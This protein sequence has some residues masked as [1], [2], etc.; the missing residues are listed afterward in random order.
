MIFNTDWILT[1]SS[2]DTITQTNNKIK[3]V[4]IKL[5]LPK[6]SDQDN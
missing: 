1:V 5:N 2:I 3:Y 6:I 4:K